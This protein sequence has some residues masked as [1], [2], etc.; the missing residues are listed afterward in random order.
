M[1]RDILW[2]LANLIASVHASGS[3]SLTSAAAFQ[4][5]L[6][7]L[8]TLGES[9]MSGT[10]I[11]HKHNRQDKNIS[12]RVTVV[13]GTNFQGLIP[14]HDKPCLAVLFVLQQSHIASSTLF[15]FSRVTVKFEE[16]SAH[17]ELLFFHLFVRLCFDLLSQANNR[18]E[19][20]IWRIRGFF[21]S[22]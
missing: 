22:M 4:T 13:I 20:N 19:V 16:L 12:G 15:P 14:P 17:L 7:S 3:P 9:F 8:P 2:L 5:Q 18:L 6:R 10:T 11:E 1:S 21:L